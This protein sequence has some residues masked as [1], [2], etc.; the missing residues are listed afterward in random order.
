M[1]LFRYVA[2]MAPLA[3][4]FGVAA[5]LAFTWEKTLRR[6]ILASL[7]VAGAVLVFLAAAAI[8]ESFPA[9][10]AVSAVVLG[11]AVLVVGL[12]CLA[13]A[14]RLPPEAC[15]IVASLAVVGLMGTVF[16][17]GPVLHHAEE[18]GMPGDEI[19]R[20]IT[21]ALDVN[22]IMVMGYSVF[23]DPLLHKPAFYGLGLA[24]YQHGT[25]RWR[26]TAA[27]YA[28]AGFVLFAFS[29]ALAA[30]RLRL[31]DMIK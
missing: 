22:P 1:T 13:A 8:T 19:Y 24:D 18:V 30:L 27:G 17:F 9:W 10:V 11:L 6:R 29:L 25:P 31:S 20:R 5:A 4:G 26:V 23:D 7:A 3:I 28:L 15:Q 12:F 14:F 16:C 2:Y 21:L